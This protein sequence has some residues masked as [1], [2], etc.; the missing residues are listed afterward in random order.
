MTAKKFMKKVTIFITLFGFVINSCKQPA[1]KKNF[2]GIIYYSIIFTPKSPINNNYTLFQKSRYGDVM[3]LY[4][5][6]TGDFRREFP[7]SEGSGFQSI[8]Y[9]TATNK[10][11]MQWRNNDT[12]YASTAAVNSLKFV[13]EE[14]L[15]DENIKGHL[16]KCY[17][18]WGVITKNRQPVSFTY[19]YPADKEYIDP[20][21]YK[22]Y[23]DFLYNKAI[24]KMKAP[25]YKLIMDMGKYSIT[26]VMES[27]E[28]ATLDSDIFK[29]PAIYPV[30]EKLQKPMT[31]VGR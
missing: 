12:I 5:S 30:M 22:N 25:Y 19:F 26:L 21:L 27:I 13:S 1:K 18:V 4:V 6:S 29:N 3:K 20:D 17:T 28:A 7:N 10:H 24:S 14:Q 11:L 31:G 16:C 23:N 15:P 8:L 9:K 2:E